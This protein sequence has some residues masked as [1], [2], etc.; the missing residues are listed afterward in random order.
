MYLEKYIK[1][2]P[3]NRLEDG[4]IME[5]R[6]IQKPTEKQNRRKKKKEKK[7]Q[8]PTRNISNM[9]LLN[10]SCLRLPHTPFKNIYF[11]SSFLHPSFL[12]FLSILLPLLPLSPSPSPFRQNIPNPGNSD[13]KLHSDTAYL[14]TFLVL[15]RNM[16]CCRWVL[17]RI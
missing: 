2:F 1:K 10:L 13:Y 7:N 9:I 15:A 4:L 16:R 3:F 6:G 17:R 14:D 11:S 5:P 12:F 8:Y